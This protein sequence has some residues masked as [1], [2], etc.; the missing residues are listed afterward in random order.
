MAFPRFY[1]AHLGQ[2]AE[3]ARAAVKAPRLRQRAG[4]HPDF[5]RMAFH[6]GHK[7][8]GVGSKDIECAVMAGDD[9]IELKEALDRERGRLS[10]HCEAVADRHDPNLRCMNFGDQSHIGKKIRIAHVVDA[11]CV[12]GFDDHAVVGISKVDHL[13]IDD[14][15]G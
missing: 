5:C 3:T 8:A 13:A 4:G 12:F 11:G 7:G 14:R 9:G 6:R 10:A 1:P 2:A 15:R